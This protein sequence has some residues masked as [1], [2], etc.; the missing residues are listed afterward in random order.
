MAVTDILPDADESGAG[1]GTPSS[2]A[3]TGDPIWDDWSEPPR[4]PSIP[5][6]HL[7][8]F[9]GPM[10][11]LLDL[12]ERQR[13][14]FGRMS[15]LD[16]AEQFVAA[17]ERLVGKVALERRADWHVLAARLVLLRSRL[18]FPGSP[19]EAASAER[20]AA[21]ELRRLEAMAFVRAASSWLQARPQLGQEVFVRPAAEA[22]RE[23]GYVALMEA[24]LVVLRGRA[25]EAE[26]DELSLYRPPIPN[27]WLVPDALARIRALLS[28]QP[29]GG[30]LRRFLPAIAADAPDRTL[31]ARAAVASTLVAG[32]ELAREGVLEIQQNDAFG[33]VTLTTASG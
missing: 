4:V 2:S 6:L 27:L 8:G 33:A 14:N 20:D 30:E 21:A 32:L 22:P 23:S 28:E 15:I 16:L 24:C 26:P 29:E 19:E 3:L 5:V 7:D 12:A 11:L 18:M 9:D 25:G 1:Q 10:D 31:Q 17:V 13:I